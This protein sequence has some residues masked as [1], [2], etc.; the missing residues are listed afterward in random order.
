MGA[1]PQRI[2]V[3][4]TMAGR[5][6]IVITNLFPN[7]VEKTRGMFVWQETR[8][9]L[10]RHGYKLRVLSPLPWVPPFLRTTSKFAH[11]GVPAS[12]EVEDLRV[13]YPRHPVTPRVGRS[14]YGQ[15]MYW[16]LSRLFSRL[17]KTRPAE[18][19]LAHY[20]FPDGYAAMRLARRHGLP[21]LVKVRG[22]DVNVFTRQ[23]ARRRLTVRT[24][25][26]ADRVIAVSEALKTKMID[27]G[28]PAEKISVVTNG[29]NAQ[30][31]IPRD[32]AASRRDLGLEADP[33]TFL[34]IG[35]L[36]PLKG[37]LTMLQAFRAIQVE[38][39]R[40]ARL[41]IIG[42]G[43][44]QEEL[45][46]RIERYGL[47]DQVRLLPPMEHSEIPRWFGA[48]DCLVLPSTNEGYPN[49]VV[50]ALA[51]ARPVIA[52]RVGGI[53]EIVADGRSGILVPPGRPWPLTDAM[54]T[55]IDGFDFDPAASPAAQRSWEDVSDDMDA[56]IESAIAE[57]GVA[58]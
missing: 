29:V 24:L 56:L 55:M 32:R 15:F 11:A 22:S 38:K 40:D 19:V 25:E 8:R 28:V 12:A 36:R 5:Q 43:E 3:E 44:L 52:S 18:F 41:V 48:C 1:K 4:E 34:F 23:A 51:A 30:R 17:Q 14:L 9:L 42:G 2:V 21:L 20:A 13:L 46:R 27:L 33:F 16:S 50:E 10:E 53:P 47:S 26:S 45:E 49:V 6:G 7:P 31:F 35:S 39:R 57:R 54:V 37:V 58:G